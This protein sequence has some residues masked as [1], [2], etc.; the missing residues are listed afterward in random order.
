MTRL[1]IVYIVSLAILVTLT[2]LVVSRSMIGDKEYG[3]VLRE[4]ILETEDEWIVELDIL[5]HEGIDQNYIISVVVDNNRHSENVLIPDGKM[6]TYIHHV[7]RDKVTEG[8]ARITIY[9]EGEAVPLEES[10]Y[11]IHF[12]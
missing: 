12:D 2:A 5:N 9:K 3:T 10:T 11:Y 1:R 6:Y 4:E 7:Y 8:K